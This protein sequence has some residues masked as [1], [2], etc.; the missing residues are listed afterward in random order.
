MHLGIVLMFLGWAGN[1]YDIEIK[2]GIHP[3]DVVELGDYQIR[4]EGARASQDWQKDML[5]VELVAE[6]D[7]SERGR[8]YPAKWWYYQSP[9]QPTKEASRVMTVAG[10]VYASID[11][12]DMTTGWTRVNLYYNPL[13][14]WV[15]FGFAVML[16]GGF[17]CIGA[18]KEEAEGGG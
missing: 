3:G 9:D 4:Y 13:V 15:W 8:L 10:D 11:D 16:A 7:G 17:V 6:R 2:R 12:V 5:T 18:K 14:N 1:A